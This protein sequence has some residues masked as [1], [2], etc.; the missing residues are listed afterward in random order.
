MPQTPTASVGTK[1]TVTATVSGGAV[2]TF[3]VVNGGSGYDYTPP[4]QFGGPGTGATATATVVSG[5][6][7]AITLGV[8]GTGYTTPPIVT[9]PPPRFESWSLQ[10]F[11]DKDDLI[12]N[13]LSCLGNSCINFHSLRLA[14]G[15]FPSGFMTQGDTIPT[16][17]GPYVASRILFQRMGSRD[18]GRINVRSKARRKSFI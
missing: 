16:G 15:A 8:G 9:I 13:F 6:V 5:V 17:G 10:P 11:Q 7:T 1:A 12:A 2:A 18:T 3:T 4:V 14:N